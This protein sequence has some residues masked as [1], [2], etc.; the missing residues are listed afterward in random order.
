MWDAGRNRANHKLRVSSLIETGRNSMKQRSSFELCLP[1]VVFATA[2][3]VSIPTLVIALAWLT[4]GVCSI[5]HRSLDSFPTDGIP[6]Q[7]LR[8]SR[9]AGLWFYHL[10]WW[11]W[12]MRAE[13]QAFAAWTSKVLGVNRHSAPSGRP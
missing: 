9:R 3:A 6:R 5:G 7:W 4:A 11:P 8:D 10:A 12:Y 2:C 13:L 1:L